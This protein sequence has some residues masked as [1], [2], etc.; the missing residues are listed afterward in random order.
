MSRVQARLSL[1]CALVGLGA[2]V[3]AA[4]VH[5]RML[6][7]P[8]YASAC[9]INA[10]ISCTQVYASPFSTVGGLSVAVPGAVWFALAS[11]LSLVAIRGEAA[12]QETVT[13]ALFLGAT[14]SLAV[15]LYLGY[16]S[17]VVLR[18]VCLYCLMTYAAVIGLFL[19][20]GAASQVPMRTLPRRL[21][22][23]L[24]LLRRRPS[25]LALAL[26]WVVASAAAV[27]LY[28]REASAVDAALLADA[29]PVVVPAAA[30]GVPPVVTGASTPATSAAPAVAAGASSTTQ[31]A[32]TP[33]QAAR[34]QAS[35]AAGQT[36]DR[37]SDFEK[38][39][40]GAPRVPLVVPAE[41]AKVVIVKFA[42]YQCPACSQ[43]YLAYRPILAKYAASN[44]GAVKMVMKDFPLNPSCN[45]AL[46]QM[47]HPSA[48]D[49]AVAVRLA[50]A[51]GKDVAL[52]EYFY[53][54][55]KDM[56]P[57]M[58]RKA[59]RDV[60]GITDFEEKYQAT[61]QAV[62]ADTAYGNQLKVNQTPTFFINGLKIDGGIAPQYFD[63][64]IAYELQ[65]PR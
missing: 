52:E 58:V 47:I 44:P 51:H 45:G 36:Q 10:T 46:R 56:T 50:K 6:V 11:L 57:D 31:P 26:C 55:Q 43:A 60:G 22:S 62:K 8:F 41:G 39:L 42:D 32:A 34:P 49:A 15:V 65:H 23:D 64:A 21:V 35:T 18:L 19:V 27:T 24:S 7:D 25:A 53:T 16:A 63:Q 59:A 37:R 29:D 61:L 12:Q 28:P 5:G 38:Y 30:P 2:S 13:G 9:D 14:L 3:A 33:T 48:C 20:T 4:Y 17:F 54:H 1:L 40:A